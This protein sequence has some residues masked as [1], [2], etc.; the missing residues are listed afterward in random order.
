MALIE[1]MAAGLPVISFNCPS[2]PQEIIRDGQDGVLVPPED[3]QGLAAALD[4]L[5][6]DQALRARLAA[7]A[8]EVLDR[9]GVE[10]AMRMWEA[11]LSQTLTQ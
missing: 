9:F 3:V 1:A 7:R 2:G 8:P 10:R 6:G 4:R 5:M 11:V